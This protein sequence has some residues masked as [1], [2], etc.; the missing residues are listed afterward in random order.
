[1]VGLRGRSE[2]RF[3]IDVTGCLRVIGRLR[4]DGNILLFGPPGVGK[5]HLGSAIGL[6]LVEKGNCVLFTF[7]T[8]LFQNLQ[9]ARP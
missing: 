9:Q 2:S 8:D 1:M 7:T 4:K 5:S 6:S 3:E